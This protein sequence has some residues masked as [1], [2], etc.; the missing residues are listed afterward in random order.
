M[1]N[2]HTFDNPTYHIA[3]LET[4]AR[5]LPVS[6]QKENKLRLLCLEFSV[7]DAQSH[8]PTY[9]SHRKCPVSHKPTT[10]A[11]SIQFVKRVEGKYRPVTGLKTRQA[12]SHVLAT[13][14]FLLHLWH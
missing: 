4:L 10:V 2:H 7:M 12:T 11:Q 5:E 1:M 13:F 3:T 14:L 6:K 8:I 9:T